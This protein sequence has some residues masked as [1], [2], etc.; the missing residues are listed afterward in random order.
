[1]RDW[2]QCCKIIIR[3]M[4]VL[5]N[6]SLSRAVVNTTS[7]YGRDGNDFDNGPFLMDPFLSGKACRSHKVSKSI[8]SRSRVRKRM[9]GYY[10]P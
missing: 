9:T 6:V 8:S 1:M 7:R 3:C 4:Y 5:C 2:Y 10:Y